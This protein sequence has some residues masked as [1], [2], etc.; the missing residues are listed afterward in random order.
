MHF[1][2]RPVG[3][4]ASR[5]IAEATE[6]KLDWNRGYSTSVTVELALQSKNPDLSDD[7]LSTFRTYVTERE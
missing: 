7:I 3:V 4:R 1:P 2:L 5:R 6:G